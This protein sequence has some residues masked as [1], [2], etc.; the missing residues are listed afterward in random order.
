MTPS[1]P[2][3][4]LLDLDD[5]I[6]DYTSV[7]DDCWKQ[8]CTSFAPR[9]GD[10]QPDTLYSA[11]NQTADWYWSDPE[12]HRR[13]RLDLKTS[14]RQI[15]R[16]TLERLHLDND[17]V[18]DELADTFTILREEQVQPF[19]GAIEALREFQQHGIRM[20][21][22]TNG[23]ACFQRMKIQRYNLERFF[24]LIVIES[25]FGTGKPDPRVFLY[26]LERLDASPSQAWMI[27]DDLRRDI[28]PAQELGLATVWVD[29]AC[30]GL[31]GNSP[32]IP[33]WSVNSLAELS[34]FTVEG[35]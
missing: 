16:M 33:T 10:I 22:L 14:R 11:I 19:A 29:Y 18:G 2:S 6:L 1:L 24:E 26:A 31:P 7:R 13:G 12:R 32:L 17:P 27:G 8:L 21:L 20:A 3:F 23:N 28:Q 5:T 34:R 30:T 25:E 4:L 9:I 35:I 15:V